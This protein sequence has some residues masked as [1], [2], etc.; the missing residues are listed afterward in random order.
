MKWIAITI[1]LAV[2]SPNHSQAGVMPLVEHG[3]S[4]T[5]RGLPFPPSRQWLDVRSDW[6]FQVEDDASF[7][8][9][10]SGA[11]RKFYGNGR[12]EKTV[13]IELS[14]TERET[15]FDLLAGSGFFSAPSRVG[16]GTPHKASIRIVVTAGSLTHQVDWDPT[17]LF[18]S[19]SPQ[20]A[21]EEP[22]LRTFVE[23]LEAMFSRRASYR[24][25]PPAGT[26]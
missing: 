18:A 8:D 4:S 25:L 10:R 26:L 11:F 9:S 13:Y 2:V 12:G 15:L 6:E 24:A 14:R 1:A 7:Y 17:D 23:T 3:H 21:P 16:R 20:L 19:H 22:G 5:A